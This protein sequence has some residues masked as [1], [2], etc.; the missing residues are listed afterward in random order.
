[1]PHPKRHT[2]SNGA[3]LSTLASEM[4]ATTVYSENVDVP[5]KWNRLFPLH[6][7]RDVPSGIT[8]RPCVSRM[9]EHT[10]VFGLRQNLQSLHCGMYSGIT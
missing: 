10:L 1:M 9:R 6:V 2:L 8:P 3:D 4:A 7:K 5:M